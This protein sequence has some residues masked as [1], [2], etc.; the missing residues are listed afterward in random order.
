MDSFSGHYIWKDNGIVYYSNGEEQYVLNKETSTWEVKTWNGLTNF[1]SYHT[2]TDGTAIYYS[3]D[4]SNQYVLNREKK[5]EGMTVLAL[6][7]QHI[8]DIESSSYYVNHKRLLSEINLWREI[9]LVL[10]ASAVK[11]YFF[12]SF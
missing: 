7:I 9:I 1:T 3:K 5:D 10:K 6:M 2:W 8:E 4:S 12:L 11:C